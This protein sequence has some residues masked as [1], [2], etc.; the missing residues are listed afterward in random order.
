MSATPKQA[1]SGITGVIFRPVNDLLQE[2]GIIDTHR[3][4]K[5][6]FY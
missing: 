6:C 3:S 5:I 1:I 2:N 4:F